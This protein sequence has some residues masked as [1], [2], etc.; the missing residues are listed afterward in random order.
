LS[1]HAVGLKPDTL[2][3]FL[4]CAAPFEGEVRGSFGSKITELMIE[5]NILTSNLRDDVPD[6]WRDY[7][8]L[9]AELG[10]I[11]S[12]KIS[13]TL[14]L[15]NLAHMFLAGELGFSE[16]VGMQALRYQYPNGQKSTIGARLTARGVTAEFP[17]RP[18]AS[19]K[20]RS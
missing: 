2:Y 19:R 7:Q 1:Q 3:A 4:Q 13:P 20:C 8:Q 6:A 10:L 16:L 14:Y 9:L 5:S 17:A 11:Y 18:G 12:T 15:T